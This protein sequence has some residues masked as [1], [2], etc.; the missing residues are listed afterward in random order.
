MKRH[1][2]LHRTPKNRASLPL[3]KGFGGDDMMEDEL[4]STQDSLSTER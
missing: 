1:N 3:L 4:F 2:I